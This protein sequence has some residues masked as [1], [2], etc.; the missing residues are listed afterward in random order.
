ML[1]EFPELLHGGSGALL[2]TRAERNTGISE[3]LWRLSAPATLNTPAE[4]I[5]RAE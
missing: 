5:A 4:T 2:T 1:R 3:S